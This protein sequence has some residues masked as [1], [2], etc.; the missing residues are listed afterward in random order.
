MESGSKAM[1]R[2]SRT[3]LLAKRRDVYVKTGGRKEAL[4]CLLDLHFGPLHIFRNDAM[5]VEHYHYERRTI[6]APCHS[7]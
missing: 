7:L 4:D 6:S 2:K 3:F 5:T 1:L